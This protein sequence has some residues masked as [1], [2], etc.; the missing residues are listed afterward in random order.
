MIVGAVFIPS[1]PLL[2]ADV[3]VEGLLDDVRAASIELLSE[4]LPD[5][6]Q[7]IAIGSADETAWFD[8]GGIGTSKGL[9]GHADFSIG[10]GTATLPLALTIAAFVLEAAGADQPILALSVGKQTTSTERGLIAQEVQARAADVPT[11]LLVVG[12]GSATRTEKA[13]GYIQP[14]A[15][16]FDAVVSA[17]LAAADFQTLVEITQEQAERLWCQGLPAW[18]VAALA[19]QHLKQGELALET[20]PFGVNYLVASWRPWQKP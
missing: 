17:A 16:N 13:P 6:R 8:E 2:L 18:Q 20:A 12:D 10:A 3:D 19:G 7:I 11:V 14:D 4:F 1:S 5:A 9:G 15:L